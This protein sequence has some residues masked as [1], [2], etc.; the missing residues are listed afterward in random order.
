MSGFGGNEGH[1]AVSALARG[2]EKGTTTGMEI[3]RC[4]GAQ[5]EPDLTLGVTENSRAY[6]NLVAKM[7]HR[8]PVHS[9]SVS[10]HVN[11]SHQQ[12][13]FVKR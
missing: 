12:G 11:I 8:V 7:A 5:R 13:I 3:C 6:A 10:P 2:R 4:S 1:G 9:C